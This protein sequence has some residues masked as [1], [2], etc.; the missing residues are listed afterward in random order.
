LE[1]NLIG[2]IQLVGQKLPG[3]IDRKVGE[4]AT[5]FARPGWPI[6]EATKNHVMATAQREK[7]LIEHAQ[8]HWISLNVGTDAEAILD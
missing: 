4:F 5:G 8:N 2:R 7:H 6:I 1:I 3:G